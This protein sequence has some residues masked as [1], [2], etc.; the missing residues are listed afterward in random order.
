MEKPNLNYINQLSG[1]DKEFEKKMINLIKE[2]FTEERDTYR[3]NF[4]SKN[5]SQLVDDVHKIKHKISILGLEKSYEIASN[6]EKNL[7]EESIELNKDFNQ[8][9][10][11]MTSFIS[12]L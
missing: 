4:N 1:G 10:E 12:N 5:Y 8:I 7:R 11:T 6:Y 3:I 2:E 9:L